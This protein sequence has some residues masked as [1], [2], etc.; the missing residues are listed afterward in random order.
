MEL[1]CFDPR[2]SAMLLCGPHKVLLMKYY[3]LIIM[4][5]ARS[6]F[7]R[8]VFRLA[9]SSDKWAG[10]GSLLGLCIPKKTGRLPLD[11]ST[12]SGTLHTGNSF[13]DGVIMYL[14]IPSF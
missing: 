13:A 4:V 5:K 14:V 12:S 6:D 10:T 3:G 8:R 7:G 1:V 9:G 2:P 11:L